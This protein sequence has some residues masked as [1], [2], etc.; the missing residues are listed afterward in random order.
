MIDLDD[1]FGAS[2]NEAVDSAGSSACQIVFDIETGPLS[3]AEL[4]RV[5]PP[6]DSPSL[7][8]P[9]GEFDESEVKLGRLKDEEKIREKVEASRQQHEHNV[10]NYAAT[11]DR[12]RAKHVEQ[13]RDMAALSPVTGRVLAIGYA[14]I[15]PGEREYFINSGDEVDILSAFWNRFA[16]CESGGAIGF[17]ITNFD[18]PFLVRRSWV[19]DVRVPQDVFN[20]TGRYLS[21]KFVDLM[22]VWKC[23][24]QFGDPKH[25][26]SKLDTVAKFF[27]LEGKTP[28]VTGA[29][30]HRLWNGSEDDRRRAGQYLVNDVK[31]TES[32][33]AR[34]CVI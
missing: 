33:A 15:L 9:P 31:M 26:N 7:P 12:I 16:G 6:L 23:A 14:L 24:S 10:R 27:G 19:N 32:I 30:F 28:G 29:D 13:F 8:S 20:H 21:H 1:I 17:N 3:D 18:V 22:C 5:R 34:M 2:S 11:C 4:D 25:V